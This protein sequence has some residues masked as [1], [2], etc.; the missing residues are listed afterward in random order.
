M[1]DPDAG[2]RDLPLAHQRGL[3]TLLALGVARPLGEL[4]H[5]LDR[6]RRQRGGPVVGQQVDI[7]PLGGHHRVETKLARQRHAHRHAVGIAARGADIALAVERQAIDVGGDLV[8]EADDEHLVGQMN[9]GVDLVAEVKQDAGVAA[10]GVDRDVG[11]DRLRL[12]RTGRR[13]SDE[14][15][16]KR[17]RGKR[18][19]DARTRHASAAASRPTPD[20]RLIGHDAFCAASLR[21]HSSTRQLG[22]H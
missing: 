8:L 10:A 18:P 17:Q 21:R 7:E 5:H 11:L 9:V 14:G 13:D 2:E 4:L 19:R 3:L 22:S 1:G 12:D 20:V 6:Q 15:D 16:G